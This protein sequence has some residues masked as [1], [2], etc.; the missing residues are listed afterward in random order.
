[1]D[2]DNGLMK[3]L[4]TANER[5]Q[6]A[7]LNADELDQ[8]LGYVLPLA[9]QTAYLRRV[10]DEQATRLET[11]ER[12]SE[13]AEKLRATVADLRR[14]LDSEGRQVNQQARQ[15]NNRDGIIDG[16]ERAIAIVVD[17]FNG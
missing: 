6:G 11:A 17:A 9:S 4:C 16:L 7:R 2:I 3:R 1:M 15:I 8:L 12:D 5:E 14:Q 10:N 13:S